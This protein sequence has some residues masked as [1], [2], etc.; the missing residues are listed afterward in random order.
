ME[1]IVYH[2][3]VDLLTISS[4]AYYFKLYSINLNSIQFKAFALSS[5][6]CGHIVA[7]EVYGHVAMAIIQEVLSP[8]G[9]ENLLSCCADQ[10]TLFDLQLIIVTS[11]LQF[12]LFEFLSL[13]TW[14]ELVID[15]D[16]LSRHTEKDDLHIAIGYKTKI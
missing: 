6:N 7:D 14:F 16:Y 11:H 8:A 1:W 9:G 4:P 10:M 12:W 15:L 3:S 13:T 5:E 2:E